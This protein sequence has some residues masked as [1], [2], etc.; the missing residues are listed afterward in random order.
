MS[1][2]CDDPP[3]PAGLRDVLQ[4]SRVSLSLADFTQHDC[5]LIAVNERFCDLSGYRQDE[6]LGRNCR[7][8]QPSGGAG[9]VRERMR[10]FL[11]DASQTHGRFLIPNIRRNGK[12]FLNLVYMSKLYRQGAVAMVLGSQFSV[13]GNSQHDTELYDAALLEDLRILKDVLSESAML[14]A[15]SYESLASS[16]SIVAQAKLDGVDGED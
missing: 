14:L 6:V 16:H 11:H 1:A 3:I 7:F 9:P 15:G 10:T 2:S 4:N 13:T 12:L 8:L 5:P